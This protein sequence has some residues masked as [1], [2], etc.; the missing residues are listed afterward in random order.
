MHLSALGQICARG[1]EWAMAGSKYI[2]LSVCICAF[3]KYLYATL[4][5]VLPPR[6]RRRVSEEV[7]L[8]QARMYKLGK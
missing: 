6:I 4:L 8:A 1:G 2:V 3:H 7:V 5:C